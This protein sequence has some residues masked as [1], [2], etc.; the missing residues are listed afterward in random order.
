MKRLW[1]I[2]GLVGLIGLAVTGFMIFGP[3]PL[4]PAVITRAVTS[5][6]LVPNVSG[7]TVDRKSMKY[8]SQ[9][10]LLTYT[11]SADSVNIV[12]SQQP[13]PASFTDIPQVYDKVVASMSEYSTFE[14]STGTVHLTRPKDLGGKQAAVMN[15]K[16]TLMFVKPARD[17]SEDQWRRLF[18]NLEVVK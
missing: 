9:I 12:V 10:K 11:A 13:T 16:G 14:S 4:V 15:A 1:L 8:D 7:A 18:N 5:T 6:I 17:L 3:K 2:A